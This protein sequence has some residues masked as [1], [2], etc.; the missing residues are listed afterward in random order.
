MPNFKNIFK[1]IKEAWFIGLVTLIIGSLLLIIS[2][3]L[4]KLS[5]EESAFNSWY[6]YY[7]KL[8]SNEL[9]GYMGIFATILFLTGAI[10]HILLEITNINKWYCRSLK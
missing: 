2:I 1:L 7:Y 4:T 10:V 6:P 9:F 8:S 3:Q 5:L